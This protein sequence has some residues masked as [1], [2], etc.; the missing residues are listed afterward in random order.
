M[1]STKSDSPTSR[2]AYI[3]HHYTAEKISK[4]ASNLFLASWRKK[5]ASSMLISWCKER[6]TDP[7]SDPISEVTNV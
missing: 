5:S 7:V 6:D 3:K 2:V 4:P 1:G